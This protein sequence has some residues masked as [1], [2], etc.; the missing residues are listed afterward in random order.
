MNSRKISC[1]TR[2]YNDPN[3]EEKTSINMSID[4]HLINNDKDHP[5]ISN[6]KLFIS[7]NINK[8]SSTLSKNI[9]KIPINDI[10]FNT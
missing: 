4:E 7:F 10:T 6:K 8:V 1:N 3:K 2:N 5:P 9:I